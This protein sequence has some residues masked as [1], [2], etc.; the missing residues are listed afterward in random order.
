MGFLLLLFEVYMKWFRLDRLHKE[1]APANVPIH[2]QYIY[3]LFICALGIFYNAQNSWNCLEL[4][5]SLTD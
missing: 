5:S 2:V 4:E 3:V 1:I